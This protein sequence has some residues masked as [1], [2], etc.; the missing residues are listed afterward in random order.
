FVDRPQRSISRHGDVGRAALRPKTAP[1]PSRGS[2]CS[3]MIAT[4]LAHT[5]TIL[6]VRI[7]FGSFCDR[8][9]WQGRASQCRAV[10][11][12]AG[13]PQLASRARSTT[14]AFPGL[15]QPLKASAMAVV[16]I[17]GSKGWA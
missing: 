16:S 9:C 17:D 1:L 15:S 12:L 10:T 8:H 7:A 4:A 5:P 6:A 2:E 14:F 13:R 3:P 11:E